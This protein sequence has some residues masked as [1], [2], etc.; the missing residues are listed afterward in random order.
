MM[1]H[2]EAVEKFKEAL[3]LDPD[4]V[5]ILASWGVALVELK[6]FEK[7]AEKFKK[8]VELQPDF[9]PALY[10][11]GLSLKAQGK[12]EEAAE[13]FQKASEIETATQDLPNSEHT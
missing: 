7:A 9:V 3:K 4:N 5:Q 13:K 11:W 1:P 8:A 2:E 10:G 6:Q 12:E